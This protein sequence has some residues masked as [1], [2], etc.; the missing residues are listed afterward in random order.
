MSAKDP[1]IFGGFHPD[2]VNRKCL[3]NGGRSESA[4]KMDPVS[5]LLLRDPLLYQGPPPY[6]WG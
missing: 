1:H 2:A 3:K 4:G 5:I 6:L